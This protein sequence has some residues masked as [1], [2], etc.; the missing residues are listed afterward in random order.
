M[1]LRRDAAVLQ[2]LPG[3]RAGGRRRAAR[4]ST[5]AATS[6]TF[7]SASRSAASRRASSPLRRSAPAC[8]TPNFCAS[9]RT[10]SGNADLLVQL[11]E[12]EHVAADAAAEAVE[13]PLVRVDVKRR[14][15]LRMERTETLVRRAR[16]LQRHVLL[17][18]LQDVGLHAQVVDELLGKQSHHSIEQVPCS[19]F[20]LHDRDAAAALF[21]R[22]G[23]EPRDQR[24]LLQKAGRAPA[25]A[26]RC[27]TRE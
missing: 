24:M 8:A 16:A 26:D 25:S 2:L 3:A 27:R 18:D 7:S 6:C 11:E 10:A 12:L 1:R 5:A 17:H 21:G 15:L 14:R 23:G 9:I 20:Q 4:G 22:R 13:E 19:V